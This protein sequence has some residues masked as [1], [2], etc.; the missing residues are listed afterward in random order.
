ML[1]EYRFCQVNRVGLCL[2]FGLP[3]LVLVTSVASWDHHR[4][5]APCCVEFLCSEVGALILESCGR[6]QTWIALTQRMSGTTVS[7]W[8]LTLAQRHETMSPG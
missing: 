7:V 2:H 5:T 4:R 8:S 1:L 6:F 3:A